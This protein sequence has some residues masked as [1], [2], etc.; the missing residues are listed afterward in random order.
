MPPEHAR[1]TAHGGAD[2][3]GDVY[4]LGAGLF[5]VLTGALPYDGVT[6][7]EIIRQLLFG[8]PR[9]PTELNPEVPFELEAV[10]AAAM[11]YHPDDRYPTA[12]ELAADLRAWLAGK[13]VSVRS[14]GRLRRLWDQL[15]GRG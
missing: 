9:R 14:R 1:G 12:A 10:C 6:A 8:K 15:T 13:S 3:R 2:H 11:A 7:N 5:E 4:S